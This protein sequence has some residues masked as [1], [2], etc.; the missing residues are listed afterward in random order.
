MGIVLIAV[1]AFAQL[2]TSYLGWRVTA[3]PPRESNKKWHELAFITIGM[4]GVILAVAGAYYSDKERSIL[5]RDID[6][7]KSGQQETNSGI[8]IIQRTIEHSISRRPTVADRS[9]LHISKFQ[10][11]PF[12]PGR[13][14]RLDVFFEN[15]GNASATTERYSVTGLIPMTTDLHSETAKAETT[16]LKSL[17]EITNAGG[18]PSQMFPPM[19]SGFFSDYGDTLTE[20]QCLDIQAGKYL[21]IFAGKVIYRDKSGSHETS[22]CIFNKGNPEVKFVCSKNNDET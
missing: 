9:R 6:Y 20:Q 18:H 10:V 19:Q 16:F 2:C 7:L 8:S 21:M 15:T 12:I 5:R 11:A 4:T 17:D 13:P 3:R 22:Y 1:A 14:L